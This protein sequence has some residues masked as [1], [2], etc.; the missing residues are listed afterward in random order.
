MFLMNVEHI[1]ATFL[2]H[3]FQSIFVNYSSAIALPVKIDTK[4]S[5]QQHTQ[6]TQVPMKVV[7]E[8]ICCL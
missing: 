8:N 6:V 1:L 2:D 3:T 7:D 4:K 5:C